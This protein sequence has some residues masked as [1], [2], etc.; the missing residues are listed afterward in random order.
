M[1]CMLIFTKITSYK[2]YL[3]NLSTFTNLGCVFTILTFTGDCQN[4][5]N[6]VYIHYI[7]AYIIIVY[8]NYVFIFF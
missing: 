8:C 5:P 1:S 4:S 3:I 6:H 7:S 2:C